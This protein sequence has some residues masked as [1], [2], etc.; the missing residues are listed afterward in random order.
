MSQHLSGEEGKATAD[1]GI[2]S[3]KALGVWGGSQHL[4]CSLGGVLV[5]IALPTCQCLGA[6]HRVC[7]IPHW[8][9]QD[10]CPYSD[11]A[12]NFHDSNNTPGPTAVL[13]TPEG[14]FAWGPFGAR[15]CG[16][17]ALTEVIPHRQNA[18][19]PFPGPLRHG[20]GV[21]HPLL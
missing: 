2:A 14:G 13:D 3:A 7:Y 9:L 19:A 5:H 12:S 1:R 8:W 18:P 4:D 6:D 17:M 20:G 21:S 16:L 10:H 11:M 15:L